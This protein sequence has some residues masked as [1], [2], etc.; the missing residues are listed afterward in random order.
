MGVISLQL[1]GILQSLELVALDEMFRLRPLEAVDDRIVII[2]IDDTDIQQIN[3]WPL[4]DAVMAEALA[5][6]RAAEPRAIGLDIYRELPV[7]PGHADLRRIFATTPN[8]IGI[9]K[10]ADLH[11][12]G[13]QPPPVLAEA[14]QIGFN[15]VIIDGDNHVR[16]FLLFSDAEGV[17]QQSFVLRLALL[18]LEEE[19]ITPE[20]SDRNPED[21]RLGRGVFPRLSPND[22]GYVRADM[23]GY[24]VLAN[25][26]GPSGHFQR[27]SLQDLLAGRVPSELMRDRIVLIGS[28]ADSLRDFFYTAYSRSTTGSS[29]QPV[30]GVELQANFISQVLAAA[31]DG[32]PTLRILPMAWG[33]G[34]ILLWASVGASLSWAVRSP[35]RTLI[36]VSIMGA[37]LFGSC[38][39]LF[40]LGWWVPLVPPFLASMIAAVVITGYLAQLEEELKRSKDFLNSIIDTIPDPV[41]VKDQQHRWIVVNQAYCRLIG[42]AL[43]DLLDKNEFDFFA[44]DQAAHFWHQDDLTFSS[45]RENEIEEEFKDAQGITYQIATKRS[46]HRDRAGNLFLVGVIRDITRRKQIEEALRQTTVELTRSNVEL[47]QA[48]DRLSQM[49]YHDNLTGL[50]NRALLEDHLKQAIITAGVRQQIV[51]VFFL[52]LD[53]FKQ[54]NDTH[55]HLVG[56]LLLQAVAQR[57]TQCL[58]SSDLV[59]R[60]GG[61]EF[62]VLLPAIPGRQE[63]ARVAEKILYSLSRQYQLEGNTILVTTSVG[64]SLFP[65]AG[66][67]M[68]T[69]VDQADMAMYEAKRMGKNR[70]H[71]AQPTPDS[72]S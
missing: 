43:N 8:L 66:Q 47:R 48:K 54:V 15:N 64:I 31:L 41:F 69:L 12:R 9:E 57:L 68:E 61:D 42:Y 40:L 17:V 36:G 52:D 26:R 60:L 3:T 51:A 23:G 37:M 58:R 65:E 63:A 1:M 67:D 33:W 24:Q 19:G 32:R 18:Y 71:F 70:F 38:Y 28:T 55:G 20:A 10:L 2:G 44:P 49:V 25:P 50:P 14:D 34:W 7:Q 72:V 62:V 39:G 56:N 59:A 35:T 4:P 11:S 21:L 13:I 27:F 6:I 5:T 45:G 22:G 30:A 16:R 53:G 46:L 29:A